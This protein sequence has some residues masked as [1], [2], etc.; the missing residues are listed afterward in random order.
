MP[1]VKIGNGAIISSR[2]VVVRDV[3]PYT[4]VG[5][6]PASQIKE[7]FSP[8]AI[9]ALE[10]IAWWDWAI[11]KISKNLAIIVSADVEALKRCSDA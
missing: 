6:N 1:G 10:A 2:S 9:A 4:I 3:P 7:R 11:E 5:V 8:Q